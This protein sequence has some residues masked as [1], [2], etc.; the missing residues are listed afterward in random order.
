MEG[1]Y[2]ICVVDAEELMENPDKVMS[3]YCR[4]NGIPYHESILHWDKTEDQERA[5]S[6]IDR[7]GFLVTFHKAVLQSKGLR[8]KKSNE[9]YEQIYQKWA[10]EFGDEGANKIREAANSQ[11]NDYNYLK[12][13]S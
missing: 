10:Q 6:V 8:A 12:G 4:K 3:A 2:D 11:M 13:F 9:Y 1:D 7:W 5:A